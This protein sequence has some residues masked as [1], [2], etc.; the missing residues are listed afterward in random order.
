MNLEVLKDS[1]LSV[2][3][4]GLEE[5]LVKNNKIKFQS[6]ESINM[7][8]NI[9]KMI[10]NQEIELWVYGQLDPDLVLI[11]SEL[12][13]ITSKELDWNSINLK[14]LE[15]KLVESK[16][17]GSLHMEDIQELINKPFSF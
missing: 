10:H 8:L 17:N 1:Q 3:L 13:L 14:I 16:T 11:N 12:K 9:V 7:K 5:I 2:G 15:L 6:S 4:N